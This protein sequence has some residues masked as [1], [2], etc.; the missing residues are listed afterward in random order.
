[1]KVLARYLLLPM[2]GALAAGLVLFAGLVWILQLLR[3]GHHL[4]GGTSGAWILGQVFLH[5]LP[6]LLVFSFPLALAAAI[7]FTF[8]RLAATDELLAMRLAG[9]S[10]LQLALPGVLVSALAAAACL[11]LAALVEPAALA[12][13]QGVVIRHGAQVLV[14]G[15][16]PRNFQQLAS[17]TTLYVEERLP[18]TEKSARF[19][20][21]LLARDEEP[22]YVLLARRASAEVGADGS[23]SL[24]LEDAEVHT[25]AAQGMLRRVRFKTGELTLD[26]WPAVRPHLGFV[27][28]LARERRGAL[29]SPF[30]CLALG[31]L[32]LAIG[33]GA[34]R[35]ANMAV[36][37]IVGVAIYEASL[38]GASLL[39]PG[40]L[41]PVLV[42]AG[43]VM[44]AVGRLGARVRVT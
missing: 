41:A 1:M 18:G 4:L 3:V 21:L 5:S 10:P 37:G 14:L 15:A 40:P 27:A 32:A 42:S 17:G 7:L 24:R 33:L 2:G 20:G 8:G 29:S 34:G 23:V 43:V 35:P 25:T 12:R 6:T 16:R 38:W 22:S 44:A 26:L 19:S 11:A 28:D 39:W 13:L 30:G 31:V 9:A 36:R